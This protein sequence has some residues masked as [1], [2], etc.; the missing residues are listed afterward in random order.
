MQL[1]SL[2]DKLLTEKN[3]HIDLL[4]LDLWHPAISGNKWFKLKY[5]LEQARK[6]NKRGLLS[7]GG[8]YSNHLHALAYAGKEFSFHTVGIIRGEEVM[9]DTLSDCKKWGMELHFISRS[10]YKK[11][12][13]PL[14]L[15]TIQCQ[16]P[17]HYIIPEGGNN[18]LGMLGCKEI[19]K[20]IDLSPYQYIA[21]AIGTGA[22]FTGL[23]ESALPQQHLIGFA[24][25]KNGHYL[26]EEILKNT[27][28]ANWEIK[29]EYHF[30]GFAKS[31]IS[32]LEWMKQFKEHHGIEL[33][34]IYTA[35]MMYG[36]FDIVHKDGFNN[37]RI[38]AI[39]T[40][41]LQGNRGLI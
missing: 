27:H 28:K 5:N 31:N 32:L 25:L 2:T 23:I 14:F 41:G 35:K 21:C 18:A 8:A 22:T 16:Y 39:H 36:L 15:D 34:F 26:N 20:D 1:S 4:R 7:F 3:T 29:H 9:N 10:E 33:D 40:G 17:H 6:E 13:D 24:A 38:L 11:K 19:L 30:G 12:Y 37:S